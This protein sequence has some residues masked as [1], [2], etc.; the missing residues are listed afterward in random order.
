MC[1]FILYEIKSDI[2]GL[3]VYTYIVRVY[4]LSYLSSF[5]SYML[6]QF[7]PLLVVKLVPPRPQAPV[8]AVPG[9]WRPPR[10]FWAIWILLLQFCRS[11]PQK[12][13]LQT[14]V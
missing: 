2:G 11:Y 4:G 13:R 9:S 1:I 3:D 14:L 5:S 10:A 7:S 12:S 6:D 8:A